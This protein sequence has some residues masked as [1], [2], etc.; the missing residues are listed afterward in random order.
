MANPPPTWPSSFPSLLRSSSPFRQREGGWRRKA[1]R[2]MSSSSSVRGKFRCCV[3]F[4]PFCGGGGLPS[5]LFSLSL[6]FPCPRPPPP[7]LIL[8][9]SAAPP[10][11]PCLWE[12]EGLS[13]CLRRTR[14][15]RLLCP[16]NVE[17]KKSE[18]QSLFIKGRPNTGTTFRAMFLFDCWL[19]ALPSPPTLLA[20]LFSP[21]PSPRLVGAR[22]FFPGWE[23]GGGGGGE[24]EEFGGRQDALLPPPSFSASAANRTQRG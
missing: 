17:L 2:A 11:P 14:I 9:P 10:P 16:K 13:S 4:P 5:F 23:G 19:N 6:Y 22:G 8:F 7:L 21:S 18:H 1:S 3:L 12:S 20:L 15:R 24:V